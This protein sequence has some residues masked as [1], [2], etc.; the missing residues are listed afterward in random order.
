MLQVER[1]EDESLESM[2]RRFNKKVTQS[3][4]M[5]SARRKKFFEKPLTK[6]AER[7]IAIRKRI[8]KE[9]KTREIFAIRG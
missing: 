7:E 5:T 8:R 9:Q 4:L 2:I 1:K 3:G 6:R